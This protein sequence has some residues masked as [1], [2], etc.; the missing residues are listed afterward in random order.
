MPDLVFKRSSNNNLG[1]SIDVNST[2]TELPNDILRKVSNQE[3]LNG[4][5]TYKCMYVYNSSVNNYIDVSLLTVV[6]PTDDG[7][8]LTGNIVDIGLGTSDVNNAEQTISNEKVA[9]L[10]VTFS[11]YENT[12]GVKTT[13]L[14]SLNA[15]DYK[16][17]WTKRTIN[18]ASSNVD[19][20]YLVININGDAV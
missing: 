6:Q 13:P 8:T 11:D 3:L 5:I 16:A 2:I 17:F 18:P 20:V 4:L 9:P 14:F 12:P 15:G 19:E 7:G 10:G 1:G